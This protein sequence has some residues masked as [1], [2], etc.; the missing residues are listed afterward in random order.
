MHL[1]GPQ[2]LGKPEKIKVSG[3]STLHSMFGRMMPRGFGMLNLS[4]MNFAG[5]GVPIMDKA[6]RVEGAMPLEDLL[7]GARGRGVKLVACSMTMDMMGFIIEE[8]LLDGA[9]YE[10]VATYLP[11][12]DEANVNL[13]I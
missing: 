4:R 13:F 1:L 9:K 8:E 10:S 11:E 2:L 12:A 5:M 7:A 6:M 3:K